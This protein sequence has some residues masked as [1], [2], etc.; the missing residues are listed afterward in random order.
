MNPV[1]SANNSAVIKMDFTPRLRRSLFQQFIY[2]LA[3]QS[4]FVRGEC[5]ETGRRKLCL[6]GRLHELM[7]ISCPSLASLESNK[8]GKLGSV[9]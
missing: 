7:V 4:W 8:S 6:V 2:G 9:P 5:Q 3:Y 1:K